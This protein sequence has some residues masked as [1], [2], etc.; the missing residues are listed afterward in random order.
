MNR[1]ILALGMAAV[2]L[3]SGTYSYAQPSDPEHKEMSHEGMAGMH[4][5][6]MSGMHHEGM[7]PDRGLSLT[8]EQ[9]A[10]FKEI[11]RMF[12]REN[13]QLIGAL[14]AKRL[15]LRSLWTD[16]KS[17]PKAILDKEKELGTLQ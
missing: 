16:S 2:V 15:E 6:G 17:D 11:R 4:H 7:A 3:L 12:I 10:K 5:K 13:A 8:P 9:E 1:L 14:V